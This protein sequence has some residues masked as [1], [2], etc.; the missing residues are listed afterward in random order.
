MCVMI[1]SVMNLIVQPN[2]TISRKRFRRKFVYA[3]TM[4]EVLVGVAI[5]SILAALVGSATQGAMRSAA[6]LREVNAANTLAAADQDGI[7]PPGYDRTVG[8]VHWP[9]GVS[10]HGP[11]ANRYPYRLGP[12]YDYQL[13]GHILVN[14][15]ARQVNPDDTYSVSLSPAF[16]INYLFVGGEKSSAGV[17][18]I[19][20]EVASRSAHGANILVFA[21]A[22]RKYGDFITHGFN[23]LTPPRIYGSMWVGAEWKSDASPG[24]Y[25][26]VH[27]TL[28]QR[29]RR[30]RQFQLH[31]H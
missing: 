1:G 15:N 26:H 12:Y 31:G 2:F 14:E 29:R 5:I 16:G 20:D 23:I 30:A 21:S 19:P 8:E 24:N 3:F 28:E 7:F 18:T 6:Q 4:T 27:A 11:S 17:L 25:G 22:G 10:A 13:D 9:T